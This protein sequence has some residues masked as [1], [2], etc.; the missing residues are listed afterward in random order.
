[1]II[2]VKSR[3]LARADSYEAKDNTKKAIISISTPG[4]MPNSFCPDND[5]IK[6]VLHLCFHDIGVRDSEGIKMSKEDA[7]KIADFAHWCEE[8]GIE[9]IWVHCDA[10]I[11]RSSGVA[12]ALMRYFNGSDDEIFSNPRYIPNSE[13]YK[14]TVN[15]LQCR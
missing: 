10:G 7:D 3:A 14:L 1:M 13:C 5:S 12:A 9:E 2:Q 11:S 4:D 6:K 15:A 8:A